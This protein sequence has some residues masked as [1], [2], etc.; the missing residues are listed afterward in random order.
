LCDKITI[1]ISVTIAGKIASQFPPRFE[2]IF[3]TE[4]PVLFSKTCRSGTLIVHNRRATRLTDTA[5]H[6]SAPKARK[7]NNLDVNH[8]CRVRFRSHIHPSIEPTAGRQLTEEEEEALVAAID[9][10]GSRNWRM[11]GEETGLAWP[12]WRL[13]QAY[14]RVQ[15]RNITTEGFDKAMESD[16]SA[17]VASHSS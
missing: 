17:S 1:F 5:T 11:V 8:E 6:A 3:R 13:L 7:K 10:H 4:I 12:P 14:R 2:N 9:K 16:D 15:T